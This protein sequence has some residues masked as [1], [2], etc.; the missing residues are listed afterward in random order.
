MKEN[1]KAREINARQFYSASSHTPFLV[2]IERPTQQQQLTKSII[3]LLVEHKEQSI[4]Q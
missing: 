1:S 3:K 2:H 4:L